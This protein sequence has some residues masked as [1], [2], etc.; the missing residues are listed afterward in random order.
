M[1]VSVCETKSRKAPKVGSL[2]EVG[3][4]GEPEGDPIEEGPVSG[5]S[6]DDFPI[7]TTLTPTHSGWSDVI[8]SNQTSD[9]GHAPVSVV[10]LI[11]DDTAHRAG[12]QS[13]RFPSHDE[14]RTGALPE[15]S[16]PAIHD[17]NR[18]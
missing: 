4:S 7:F 3:A 14:C 18:E 8:Q 13:A 17:M 15:N 9:R 2:T 16:R 5:W 10:P 11:L 1:T 6:D 12:F